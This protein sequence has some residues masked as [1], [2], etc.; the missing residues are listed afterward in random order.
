MSGMVIG[1]GIGI[2]YTAN[3]ATG[4]IG[5]QKEDNVWLFN[6]NNEIL[7]NDETNILTNEENK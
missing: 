5:Q 4:V 2:R 3:S 1:F 6:D 7:W